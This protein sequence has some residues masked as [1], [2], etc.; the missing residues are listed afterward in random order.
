MAKKASATAKVSPRTSSQMGGYETNRPSFVSNFHV[1]ASRYNGRVPKLEREYFDVPYSYNA[2]DQR[3][4]QVFP[5]PS[6]Y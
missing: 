5:K 3:F 4:T 1:M 2:A 6:N